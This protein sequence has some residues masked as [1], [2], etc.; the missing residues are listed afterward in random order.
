MSSEEEEDGEG[1]VEEN[2]E[3]A[4]TSASSPRAT[5]PAEIIERSSVKSPATLD[6]ASKPDRPPDTDDLAELDGRMTRL[7]VKNG[8]KDDKT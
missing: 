6:E 8:N 5:R 7:Q 2:D 1:L 4:A 3:A